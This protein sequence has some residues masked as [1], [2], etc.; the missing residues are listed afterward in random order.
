MLVP[1]IRPSSYRTPTPIEV[2]GDSSKY[3]PSRAAAAMR[4]SW[5]QK[6]DPGEPPVLLG[7]APLPLGQAAADAAPAADHPLTAIRASQ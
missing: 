4:R 2:P 5:S 7:L 6:A 1:G 3:R